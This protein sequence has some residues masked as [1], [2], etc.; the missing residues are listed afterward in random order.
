MRAD[1]SRPTRPAK[2]EEK[3]DSE[4]QQ[5]YGDV[6]RVQTDKRIVGRSKKITGDSQTML[7]MQISRCHS[8][9]VPYIKRAPGT[10]V[11]NHRAR[12]APRLPR[13]RSLD[14]R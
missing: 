12:N 4:H 2:A 7:E 11:R 6:R 8:R 5:T 10:M 9:A 3:H 1:C 14:A 13:S